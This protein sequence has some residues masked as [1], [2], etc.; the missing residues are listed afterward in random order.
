M[1]RSRIPQVLGFGVFFAVLMGLPQ[2]SDA[3][4]LEVAPSFETR[5]GTLHK[6]APAASIIH[7]DD[8]RIRVARK[9]FPPNPCRRRRRC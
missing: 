5:N 9:H 8:G 7:V 6:L 1:P 2:H 4:S 3:R